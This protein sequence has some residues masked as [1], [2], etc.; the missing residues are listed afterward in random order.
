MVLPLVHQL[1][2]G[3]AI[4]KRKKV[5]Q[6][7]K[8]AREEYLQLPMMSGQDCRSMGKFLSSMGQVALMV[9][10]QKEQWKEVRQIQ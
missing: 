9:K 3:V 1:L 8:E 4:C 6:K 10:L 5:S 2:I 7:A